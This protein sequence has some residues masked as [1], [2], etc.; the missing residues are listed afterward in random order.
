MSQ[1]P[2][3]VVF[4]LFQH[5]IT[6]KKAFFYIEFNFTQKKCDLL[7]EKFLKIIFF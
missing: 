2:N 4:K 5:A 6:Q 7:Q 3:L 1:N